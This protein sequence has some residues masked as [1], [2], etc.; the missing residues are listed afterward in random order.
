MN[1]T[2]YSVNNEDWIHDSISLLIE[3]FIHQGC[4]QD[5]YRKTYLKQ[6]QQLG[7]ETAKSANISIEHPVEANQLL[8][9]ISASTARKAWDTLKEYHEKVSLTP[10]IYFF[11][12]LW[13]LQLQEDGNMQ[14]G[15]A[16]PADI[17]QELQG[18]ETK[19]KLVATMLLSSLL[20]SYSELITGIES[21]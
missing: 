6:K 8:E 5:A 15:T 21:E 10:A 13:R 9:I 19:G 17:N 2:A 3:R 4:L 20:D 12:R 14:E 7:N 18:E 11:K 16:E 1:R